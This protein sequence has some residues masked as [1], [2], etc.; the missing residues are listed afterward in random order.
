[1]KVKTFVCPKCGLEYE[2][3]NSI[4]LFFTPPF[5]GKLRYM[6]CPRCGKLGWANRVNTQEV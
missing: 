6:R 3:F 2:V 5:V 1:M 4:K